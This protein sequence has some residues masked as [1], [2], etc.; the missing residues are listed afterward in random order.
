MSAT[1]SSDLCAKLMAKREQAAGFA[2]EHADASKGPATPVEREYRARAGAFAEAAE[3][4]KAADA[5]V[6]RL[7]AQIAVMKRARRHADNRIIAQ[8]WNLRQLEARFSAPGS[9]AYAKLFQFA[10]KKAAEARQARQA[11]ADLEKFHA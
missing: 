2:D 5:E 3:M 4:A 8:R 9:P 10:Q 11:L 7:R 1:N 6:A